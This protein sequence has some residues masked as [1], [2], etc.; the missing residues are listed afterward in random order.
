MATWF[1]SDHH[2]GHAAILSPTMHCRRGD[3]FASIQEHD[4]ELVRRWN[5]VVAPDDE[6]FHLGD[7]AHR[8]SEE[9]ARAVFGKLHGRKHLIRGNHERLGDKLPWASKQD[10]L[11]VTVDGKHL[12]LFHYGMRVWPRMRR[13]SLHLYGHSHGALPGCSQSLDVGV[14]AWGFRPV[15][16]AEILA[17]MATLPPAYPEGRDDEEEAA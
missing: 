3:H 2:F 12:V 6:V 4:A 11:E 16:L 5:E 15:P 9:Y 14:D 17:R 10:F 8:T 7:F 13:G 1:T